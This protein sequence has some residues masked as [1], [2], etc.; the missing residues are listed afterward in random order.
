MNSLEE[1]KF[2]RSRKKDSLT[3]VHPSVLTDHM[4]QINHA[5]NWDSVKLPMKEDA[6][7]TREIKDS[8]SI[9]KIV[10]NAMNHDW[11]HLQLFRVVLQFAVIGA[12]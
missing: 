1:V 12:I 9:R 7:I 5:I 8:P 2:T 6:W 10:A 11:G 3:E 4:S